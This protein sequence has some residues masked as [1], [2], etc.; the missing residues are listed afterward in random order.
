MRVCAITNVY[1]E[2][3]NLPIWLR[4]YGR[5]LGIE[6]CIVVD[7]G[8]DSLPPETADCSLIRTPRSTFDDNKRA[9]TLSHLVSGMLEHYDA[10]IYTD[11]DEFLVADP[12]K[13]SGLRD[14]LASSNK[15]AWTAIGFDVEHHLVAEEALDPERPVLDQRSHL[16]FNS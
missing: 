7:H 16:M 9:R 13:Y 6:N 12:G 4:Y 5:E 11:C 1:N 8:S 2:F 14:Y 10:V 3:F 15:P